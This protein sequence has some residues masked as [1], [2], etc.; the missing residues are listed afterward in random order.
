MDAYRSV[1]GD[2]GD[3]DVVYNPLTSQGTKEIDFPN[4]KSKE[5]AEEVLDQIREAKR[6]MGLDNI[7]DTEL[8]DRS[9]ARKL[10]DQFRKTIEQNLGGDF[11]TVYGY[12]NGLSLSEQSEFRKS[13]KTDYA[14]IEAYRDMRDAYAEQ[15]P[16]WS[17]YYV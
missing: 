2:E 8:L 9:G 16:L 7:S 14:R 5:W 15:N 13:N 3:I 6:I 10:N 12:Y 17:N 4:D 11:Y 1:G